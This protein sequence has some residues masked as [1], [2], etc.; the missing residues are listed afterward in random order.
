M[1]D[2]GIFF[3]GGGGGGWGQENIGQYFGGSLI[4]VGVFGI[5]KTT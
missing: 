4:S 3:G 1:F 2:F 5:F